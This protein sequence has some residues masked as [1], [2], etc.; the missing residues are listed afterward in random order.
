MYMFILI[1]VDKNIDDDDGFLIGFVMKIKFKIKKLFFYCV[2][3]FNDDY[4]LMEFV[5]YVF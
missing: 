5:V 1:M 3:L 2:F 4:I